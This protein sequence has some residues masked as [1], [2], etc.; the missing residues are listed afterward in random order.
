[1]FDANDDDQLHRAEGIH[2]DVLVR[3]ELHGPDSTRAVADRA[4][5]LILG[6]LTLPVLP[7]FTG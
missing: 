2:P 5:L 1:M 7:Q 3:H 6:V 4:V